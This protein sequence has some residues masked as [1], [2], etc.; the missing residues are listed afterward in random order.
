MPILFLEIN[1]ATPNIHDFRIQNLASH[2]GGNPIH[3]TEIKNFDWEKE[4]IIDE[5]SYEKYMA[6][7]IKKPGSPERPS[8]EIL[9]DFLQSQ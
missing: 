8:W 6:T 7:Y 9:I 3:L 1:S 5:N 4:L 2:F